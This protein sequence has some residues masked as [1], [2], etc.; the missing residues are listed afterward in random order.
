M[1]LTR[2]EAIAKLWEV[3]GVDISEW[4]GE[5][6][7]GILCSKVQFIL[8]RYGYGNDFK[9]PKV[10]EYVQ[11]CID[12]ETAYGG[13]WFGTP[14]KSWVKHARSFKESVQEFGGIIYPT[15][16]EEVTGGLNKTDLNSWLYKWHN[17]FANISGIPLEDQQIYMSP[18]FAGNIE[19]N[20][21]MKLAHLDDAHW[22]Q[23]AFPEIPVFWKRVTNPITKFTFWQKTPIS[24][25]GYGV[26]SKKIDP[27]VYWGTRVDFNNEFHWNLE[28]LPTVVPEYVTVNVNTLNLRP[29]PSDVSGTRVLAT[30]VR[31]TPLRTTRVAVEDYANRGQWYQLADTDGQEIW[32][33]GWLC[34]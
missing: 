13:Y 27:Q 9:G 23:D 33:A 20:D 34:R 15:F 6:D 22:T 11:G 1:F 8:I 29:I 25:V 16:D 30:S 24:S 4:Q 18:G 3:V 28:P 19:A 10:P 31:N 12:H 14:D 32:I 17:E 26:E 7:F 5:I 21:Y 2:L